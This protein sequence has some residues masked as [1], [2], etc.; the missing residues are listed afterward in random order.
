MAHTL[1]SLLASLLTLLC[2]LLFASAVQGGYS[3]RQQRRDYTQLDSDAL[4]RVV[5]ITSVSTSDAILDYHNPDSKLA[6]ILVPRAVGSANLVKVQNLIRDHFA[7]LSTK[8]SVSLSDFDTWEKYEDTF[9]TGTPYGP[10]TFTNLVFTHDPTAERKLVIAAHVDSKFFE[11]AP[12]N[13][14]V[15][16]TDSAVPC[17]IML[18]I[19]TALSP[20]LDA[21][22][23]RASGQSGQRTTLQMIFFDGEEAFQQ[24]TNTDSIYGAR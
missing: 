4:R 24:W 7:G 14:F 23:Q 18:D 20:L 9:T 17:G 11:G 12:Q 8:A 19:A 1:R 21:S 22:L 6:Q 13:G 5:N 10:K 16:A 3:S 15:G 2:L